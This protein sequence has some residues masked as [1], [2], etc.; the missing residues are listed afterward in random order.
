VKVLNL[1]CG[2]KASSSPEVINIDWAILV[3][4]KKSPL[5]RPIAPIFLTGERLQRFTSLPDNIVLHDLSKGIPFDS[6]SVDA[7][8]HSHLLEH[9]DRN[10][11]EGFLLEVR[12]VLKPNGIQR[13]VVPDLEKL[14]KDYLSH[15]V[16][17]DEDPKKGAA[18]ETFISAIIEQSVRK[19]AYATRL[20]S[21]LRRFFV[22]LVV[23]DARKRG[24]THQWMY[25]RISLSELLIS[26]G[27]RNIQHHRYDT[28][29]I[30][31]WGKYGLDVEASGMQYKPGSLYMEARK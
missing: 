19:E 15:I 27:Y 11:A 24:E 2:A 8:Y 26:L 22:N 29:Q 13:I 23:G 9:L 4:L 18:H 5:L 28:S 6:N 20:Q 3:R 7:V 10:I 1:G 30:P 14:C 25:D 31:N 17:C 12:R 21:P 16:A